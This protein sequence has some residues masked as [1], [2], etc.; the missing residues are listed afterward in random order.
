MATFAVVDAAGVVT[1][2]IEAPD[3][4]IAETVT[5]ST[6]VE[7]TPMNPSSIGWT[8]D[9]TLGTFTPPPPA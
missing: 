8:H 7:Y 4:A 9:P 1:N 2:I 3:Q 6:C 5:G